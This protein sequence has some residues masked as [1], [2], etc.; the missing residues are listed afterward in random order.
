MPAHGDRLR[1]PEYQPGSYKIRATARD[2]AHQVEHPLPR[3]TDSP[4]KAIQD[5]L[6]DHND[7]LHAALDAHDRIQPIVRRGRILGPTDTALEASAPIVSS[8]DGIISGTAIAP[9]SPFQCISRENGTD[10]HV[11]GYDEQ[12]ILEQR[13]TRTR[14][15]PPHEGGNDFLIIGNKQ[16]GSSSVTKYS[17]GDH[18]GGFHPE[19]PY[20]QT[21]QDQE[22]NVTAT[23][24]TEDRTRVSYHRNADGHETIL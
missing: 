8:Q 9:G 24:F 22:G 17:A 14:T 3:A 15:R 10:M 2:I 13:T 21:T 4:A 19:A 1:P 12:G 7:I 18:K 16:D 5:T 20:I 6:Q 11:M 23:F